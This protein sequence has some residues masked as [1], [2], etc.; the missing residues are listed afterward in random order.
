MKT[1]EIQII[2][3][4]QA[5]AQFKES[6]N[7]SRARKKTSLHRGIYFTSLE[8]VRSLLTDKRLALLH[9]VREQSPQS[10]N[11]LAKIAGRD[12]KNVHAD[13]KLLKEYG[14]VRMN[15]RKKASKTSSQ[16]ILVPYQA[17]NIHA[18]V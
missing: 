15:K 11:Q 1:L 8:A 5:D 13:V 6:F 18:M 9:I 3:R 17:I 12:F 16:S 2:S 7:S 14:L 4:E 10:I